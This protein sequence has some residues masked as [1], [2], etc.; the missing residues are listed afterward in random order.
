MRS[1]AADPR[2]RPG[3]RARRPTSLPGLA[4]RRLACVALLLLASCASTGAVIQAG[5]RDLEP[6]GT[7]P[8]VAT[9]GEILRLGADSQ[10]VQRPRPADEACLGEALGRAAPAAG[11]V[12]K[13]RFAVLRDGSLAQF[14]YLE[15]VT[16]PQRLAIEKAFAS[17]LW[18][19]GLD[20]SGNPLAVWVIQPIKVMAAEE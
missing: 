10:G 2:H 17:C 16:D 20:P 6:G 3:P 4:G 19:P 15:P 9:G 13:V 12:N 11:V 18:N 7:P 5:P 1:P 14:S 8:P